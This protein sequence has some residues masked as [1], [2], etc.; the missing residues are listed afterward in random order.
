MVNKIQN[1]KK[2]IYLT[3][4][5]FAGLLIALPTVAQKVNKLSKEEK[6]DGWVLLFNGKNFDGW[7]QCNGTEMPANW[8]IE[9]DAM[10]VV[11]GEGK[12]PG[13]GANGDI[14]Y[15]GKKYKNFSKF[16][17]NASFKHPHKHSWC[18]NLLNSY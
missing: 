16:C 17:K 9:E 18:Q 14:L 1:M 11:L 7:R 15:P 2:N 13:Q 4:S 12:N 3:L 5:L 8:V 6:K 10:K